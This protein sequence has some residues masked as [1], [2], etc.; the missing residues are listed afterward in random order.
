MLD[1]DERVTATCA[2]RDAIFHET[3]HRAAW[4]AHCFGVYE[5]RVQKCESCTRANKCYNFLL[6]SERCLA[7]TAVH[8]FHTSIGECW[9]KGPFGSV[10]LRRPPRYRLR[11]F[12]SENVCQ[13]QIHT[14]HAAN[15]A[16]AGADGGGSVDMRAL[17]GRGRLQLVAG[18]VE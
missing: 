5:N 3:H 13:A 1:S 6:F 8:V 14:C 9:S 11:C 4:L 12:C 18:C 16:P 7:Q 17:C 15:D 2:E 10:H